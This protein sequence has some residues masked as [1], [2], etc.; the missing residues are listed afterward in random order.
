M[1]CAIVLIVY[2]RKIFGF[3]FLEIIV[4]LGQLTCSGWILSVFAKIF[5]IALNV[6]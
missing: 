2:V 3:E 6:L 4:V 5:N 1:N